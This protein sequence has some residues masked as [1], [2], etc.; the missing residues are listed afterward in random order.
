[1]TLPNVEGG[2]E[3]QPVVQGGQNLK[4]VEQAEAKAEADS[5][6]DILL[7]DVKD[8]EGEE[9]GSAADGPKSAEQGPEQKG[10]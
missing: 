2:S 7:G 3:G 10:G 5:D 4:H 8:G 1:M 6:G 9:T